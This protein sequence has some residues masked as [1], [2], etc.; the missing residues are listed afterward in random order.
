MDI[1]R[2]SDIRNYIEAFIEGEAQLFDIA[3]ILDEPLNKIH[4]LFLYNNLIDG[5][6]KP[7]P[8]VNYQDIV[9]TILL[10]Y[11][12]RLYHQFMTTTFG[13]VTTDYQR[14]RH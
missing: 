11:T 13:P 1:S 4:A 9:N 6:S 14:K 12:L 10:F 5:D 8:W 7:Q 3:N 2:I